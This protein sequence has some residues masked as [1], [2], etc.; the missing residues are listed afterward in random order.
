L[1]RTLKPT[2]AMVFGATRQAAAA[3]INSTHA[4]VV[5]DGYRA[6]DPKLLFW[7][8]ATLIDTALHA[9]AIPAPAERRG[10]RSLLSDMLTA[11]ELLGVR[12]D[13]A[14][15]D[16][17]EFQGYMGTMALRLVV[18]EQA[19][20]IAETVRGKWAV[21]AGR[22]VAARDDGRHVAGGL[23]RGLWAEWSRWRQAFT[24]AL[25]W[26]S[27]P[28]CAVPLAAGDAGTLLPRAVHEGNPSG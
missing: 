4:Y 2:L 23:A 10:R 17:A 3:S 8:L 27:R 22:M 18:T 25:A 26:T 5:G 15:R 24:D 16:V 1:L 21:R 9:C 12:R 14:P 28:A 11:G 19:R 7:V 6:D 13:L 20:A